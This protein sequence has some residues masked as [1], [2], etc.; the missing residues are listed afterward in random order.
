MFEVLALVL[1]ASALED[2]Q[3]GLVIENVTVI[4]VESGERLPSQN[5]EIADGK[6][7]SVNSEPIAHDETKRVIDGS[8]QFLIPGLWDTHVH[9]VTNWSWHAPLF[10]AHGVTSVRNM[11]TS[12]PEG[13][14]LIQTIK[15]QGSRGEAPRMIANGFI[16]GGGTDRWGGII[17]V[18]TAGEAV[19]AANTHV[20][21]SMDFIKVYGGI[22]HEGYRALLA[23]ANELGLPVDGHLPNDMRSQEA[24]ELGQRTIEHNIAFAHGCTDWDRADALRENYERPQVEGPPGPIEFVLMVRS[25]EEAR[26]E[27]DCI[28]LAEL[29]SER[30]VATVP[31]IVN[32]LTANPQV[33]MATPGQEAALPTALHARWSQMADSP[34]SE[35]VAE[36]R[37]PIMPYIRDEVGHY[38]DAGVTILAGT[39][40]GNNFLAP[41]VSLLRELELLVEAGLSNEQ[42]LQAATSAPAKVFQIEDLGCIATGCIADLVLLNA[43]PLQD[44]S[45]VRAIS[46]VVLAG[47]YQSKTELDHHAKLALNAVD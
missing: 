18:R 31:T 3:P 1:A 46:G 4:E 43:D 30:G 7:V 20:E 32:S 37:G 40:L 12:E 24:V 14:S 22:S 45:N 42:A 26:V 6:I 9:S 17:P 44:I 19:A 38:R 25:N 36:A 34:F 11:H 15:E 27:E 8:G 10:L 28:A 5:V 39:D 13:Y 21:K 47:R 33:S 41:G 23:K 16:V 29:M 35:S 2:T